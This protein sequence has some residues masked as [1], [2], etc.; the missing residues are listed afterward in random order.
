MKARKYA[1]VDALARIGSEH[2][3]ERGY[4]AELE[5]SA[6]RAL[7]ELVKFAPKCVEAMRDPLAPGS[8]G[9]TE[10]MVDLVDAFDHALHE[11]TF[12]IGWARCGEAIISHGKEE[13]PECEGYE[14]RG[15]ICGAP[16]EKGH[17][18]CANCEE[19]GPTA[20]AAAVI[21]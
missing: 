20:D 17:T 12:L 4:Y 21:Q 9:V 1:L 14:G 6:R 19:C 5:P 2:S 16:V 7:A 10:H 3:R 18:L 13:P 11:A 8:H 15:G